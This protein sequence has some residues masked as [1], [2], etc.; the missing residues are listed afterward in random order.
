MSLTMQ[1]NPT[2]YFPGLCE[3]AVAFYKASLGAEV[4][5]ILRVGDSIEAEQISPGTEHKVLRAALRIGEAVLYLS[6]GHRPGVPSFQGFSLSLKV[7]TQDQAQRIVDRLSGG[8]QLLMG[9]R[10]TAWAGTLAFV[11][12]RFGVHWTVEVPSVEPAQ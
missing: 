4:L 10:Q 11:L 2:V 3:E 12:D 1:L 9:L 5:F 6:D 7:S 8:G